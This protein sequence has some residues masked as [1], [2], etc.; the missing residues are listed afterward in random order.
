MTP[1]DVMVKYGERVITRKY[2]SQ[3]NYMKS[4]DSFQAIRKGDKWG[5]TK[6]INPKCDAGATPE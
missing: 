4:A 3:Q 6:K 1:V 5:G 2:S